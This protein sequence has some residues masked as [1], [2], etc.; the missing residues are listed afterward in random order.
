MRQEEAEAAHRDSAEKLEAL[1][2]PHGHFYS[3]IVDPAEADN[4]LSQLEAEGTPSSLS[5]LAIDREA[6]IDQWQRLLPFLADIPFHADKTPDLR[7]AFENDAYSWGDGSILHA[8]LRHHRPQRIVEIGSGWSS[9]CIVDTIERYLDNACEVTFVEPYP[10]LLKNL[11]VQTKVETKI[12]DTQVQNVPMSVFDQLRAGDFLFINST[13]VL[14]T[15]SDVCHELFEI[16]PRLAKGV[17]VHIHDIFW[18]F[19]YPRAWA[20]DQNRSW[21]EL[22]ALRAYLMNNDNWRIAF[23]NHYFAALEPKLIEET[24]PDFLKNCGGALWLERC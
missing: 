3:P 19:E 16:L 22:Y 10:Q 9:A 1:F 24:Y 5:G 7:Y 2:V 8:M 14:R 18:P 15:G 23:F 21:N 17:V 20:V 4:H 11:I 13:H 6:M 12:L